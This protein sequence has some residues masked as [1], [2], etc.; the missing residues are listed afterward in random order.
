[1]CSP[2]FCPMKGPP[3][4]NLIYFFYITLILF[5][6]SWWQ[7]YFYIITSNAL[8]NQHLKI[9]FQLILWFHFFVCTA[10]YQQIHM[11][12]YTQRVDL[13]SK[14]GTYFW[15]LL[16]KKYSA[17]FEPK[18]QKHAILEIGFFY[19]HDAEKFNKEGLRI[20]LF[21]CIIIFLLV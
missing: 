19:D 3:T 18:W 10:P 15:L 7:P 5:G 4:Q 12:V 16:Q 13:A 17:L 9:A 6:G 11:I 14:N 8:F 1:M 21:L 20:L 2:I